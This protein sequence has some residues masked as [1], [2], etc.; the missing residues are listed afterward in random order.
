MV[1]FLLYFILSEILSLGM[2]WY[3]NGLVSA[4]L[5]LTEILSSLGNGRSWYWY[6]IL[7]VLYGIGMVFYWYIMVMVWFLLYFILRYWALLWYGNGLVS[8]LLFSWRIYWAA[9]EMEDH[10]M[11]WY[12]I[13]IV[14]Y[15]YGIL[16][17]C[18]GITIK[19]YGFCFTL[20][21]QRCIER[22]WRRYIC[23]SYRIYLSNFVCDYVLQRYW[24]LEMEDHNI[25]LVWYWYVMLM[26]WF[27]LYFILTEVLSVSGVVGMRRGHLHPAASP[28]TS[29]QIHLPIIIIIFV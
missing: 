20:S 12:F 29:D 19:L 4:L 9:L 21:W 25:L 2:V 28:S 26:V 15:L 7:L 24:A 3:G 22:L 6:G 5:F 17:V 11:V 23:P 8:A 16:L 14:W 27:L 18:Y 13:G 1:L 10:G